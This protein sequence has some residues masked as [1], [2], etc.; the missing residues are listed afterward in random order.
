[1]IGE[2]QKVSFQIKSNV[3]HRLFTHPKINHGESLRQVVVPTPLRLQ[4]MET[5]HN[6]PRWEAT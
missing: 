1:M 4:V 5:A 2:Q 6:S 3:L